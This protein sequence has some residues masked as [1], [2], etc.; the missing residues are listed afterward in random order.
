VTGPDEVDV[1]G[2]DPVPKFHKYVSPPVN[3]VDRSVKTTLAPL[4]MLVL[5][6]AKSALSAHP[7]KLIASV[8]C[9]PLHPVGSV[10][11]TLILPLVVPKL[12]VILLLFG[13]V[14][15]EVIVVPAGTPHV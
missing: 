8:L 10:S 7:C 14:A 3:P 1:D 6:A 5:L 4:H 12:T 9:D 15:P 13:P 2:D 11:V